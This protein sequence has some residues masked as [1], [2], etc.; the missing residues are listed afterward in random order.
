M[1]QLTAAIVS[2][3]DE[4]KRQVARM[5]R[6]GGYRSASSKDGR[7]GPMAHYLTSRSWTS[8]RM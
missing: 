6:A 8:G 2:H 3:D 7:V 1:A 5:L 4:F